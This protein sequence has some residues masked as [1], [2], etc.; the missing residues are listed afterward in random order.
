[1]MANKSLKLDSEG[2]AALISAEMAKSIFLLLGDKKY[3]S[4]ASHAAAQGH[5]LIGDYD[6]GIQSAMQG[7]VLARD[8]GDKWGEASAMHTA[9]N[10]V[11]AKG[12]YGE[13]LKMAKEVQNLF[14]SLGSEE[15]G[16]S[17]KRMVEKI[18]E[19]MP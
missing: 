9:T 18:Q 10:G 15:M 7:A 3:Q 5:M 17:A 2:L 19:A 16:S 13:A 11:L 14:K 4:L 12:R 6:L 1:M 8:V